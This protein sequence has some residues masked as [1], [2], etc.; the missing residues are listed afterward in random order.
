MNDV[1]SHDCV[2]VEEKDYTD[3]D[4]N[5]IYLNTDT[6]N[7]G[8]PGTGAAPK[9][10]LVNS[11]DAT[12]QDKTFVLVQNST[13]IAED[14]SGCTFTFLQGI[15][16]ETGETVKISLRLLD[17]EWDDDNCIFVSKSGGPGGAGTQADP[18]DTI[19]GGIAL[20]DGTHQEIE[21]MDSETY[22][23]P[24]IEFTGNFKGMHAAIGQKST[25]KPTLDHPDEAF[26][27][28]SN[29]GQCWN[30]ESAMTL[31]GCSTATTLNNGNTVL[32][33]YHAVNNFSFEIYD[34]NSVDAKDII[35]SK[36]TIAAHRAACADSCTLIGGNFVIVWLD[37]T[38]E[39]HFFAIYDEDG[40]VV[41]AATKIDDAVYNTAKVSC[42]ALQDG[43]FMETANF[44][45]MN[46]KLTILKQKEVTEFIKNRT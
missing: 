10:T 16:A 39:D 21:G 19:A 24:G 22:E 25:F 44:S 29:W 20:C 26:S 13:I 6:G 28:Y 30:V 46:Q 8:D 31:G 37:F 11:I 2:E 3:T 14:I 36:T 42:S 27:D 33:G 12:T 34:G 35:K 7:D 15:F 32:A 41:K 38:T 23:E 45:D 4:D 9:A 5:T 17:T 1:G 40:E 43:N 18:V